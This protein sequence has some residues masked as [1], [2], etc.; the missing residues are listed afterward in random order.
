MTLKGQGHRSKLKALS[1]SVTLKTI[2][3]FIYTKIV[4]LCALVKKLY[5]ERVNLLLLLLKT[6]FCIMVANVTYLCTF[7]VPTA[8]S[9]FDLLKGRDPSY[10]VKKSDNFWLLITKIWPKMWFRK[11]HNLERSRSL[12][13]RNG[14]I[15][16][17]DLKSIDLDAKIVIVSALV[18]KLWCKT[19]FW[20]MMANVT[21]NVQIAQD[22]FSFLERPH[23]RALEPPETLPK[24]NPN[25]YSITKTLEKSRRIWNWYNSNL[26]S[27]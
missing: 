25:C 10:L 18:Q 15:G 3:L 27:C 7:H 17:L 20:I 4:I 5:G 19:S 23:P 22:A 11:G 2:D 14:T 21:R 1:D 8:Q 26:F 16:F 24:I 9:V 12:V 6:S 13:K